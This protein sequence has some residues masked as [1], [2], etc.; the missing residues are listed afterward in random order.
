MNCKDKER[1]ILRAYDRIVDELAGEG[2]SA[3][4]HGYEQAVRHRSR[5]ESCGRTLTSPHGHEVAYW[6][7]RPVCPTCAGFWARKIGRT[8][9]NASPESAAE[10]YRMVTLIFGLASTPDGAFDL[11]RSARRALSNAVDYRRRAAGI[12]RGGW[13]AFGAAG[14]LELDAFEA[15]SFTRLGSAKQA[16]YRAMGFMPEQAQGS[17]WVATAHLVVHVG[18]LGE[19]VMTALFQAVA[20]V[21]HVQPLHTGRSLVENAERVVGY[22]AKLKLSTTLSDGETRPWP[23]ETVAEFVAACMR[24]SHGRQ[25]FKL[26]IQPKKARKTNTTRVRDVDLRYLEPMPVLL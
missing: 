8:L 1:V 22:A 18:A 2:P 20:P 13:R 11:F 16:Q 3:R 7:R 23:L 6:C 4:L 24:C 25:G 17:Q 15:E 19:A 26:A 5:F 21:V 12:D 9:V 10:G 14:T